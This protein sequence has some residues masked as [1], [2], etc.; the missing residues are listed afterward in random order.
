DA[1]GVLRDSDAQ[2]KHLLLFSDGF[3]S[4]QMAGTDGQVRAAAASG[5][6][7][8]VVSMGLGPDSRALEHLSRLGGGRFYVVEDLRQLPRIFTQETVEASR[9]ALEEGAFQPTPRTGSK[10]TAGIDW[11]A[12][13]PL[14]G[15]AIVQARAG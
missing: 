4:E 10:I 11:A 15:Y 5:I 2:L 6:T 12:A 9:A 8:S 1:F 3:D 14:G 7:T 13:P